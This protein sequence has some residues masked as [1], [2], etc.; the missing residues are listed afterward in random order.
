MSSRS[1]S[2]SSLDEGAGGGDCEEERASS[3][4]RF[5]DSDG[6]DAVDAVDEID[7]D[8]EDESDFEDE[9]EEVDFEDIGSED[10]VCGSALPVVDELLG[11][12]DLRSSK[13]E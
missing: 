13:L 10:F 5:L 3:C 9:A 6:D 8:F 12:V 7:A 1:E 11:S 2:S 4:A